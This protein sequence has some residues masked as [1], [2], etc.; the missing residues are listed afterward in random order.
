ME[1][2]YLVNAVDPLDNKFSNFQRI[3]IDRL[4]FSQP[5]VLL[6]ISYKS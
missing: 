3:A 5:T 1:L 4:D 6:I 2:Q